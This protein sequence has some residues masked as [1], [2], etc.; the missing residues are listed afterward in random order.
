MPDQPT[1][2]LI[3]L[4]AGL[5]G[6]TLAY[7]LR[8]SGLAVRIL[9]ARDRPG[10]RICTVYADH[11]APLELGATWLGRK[12]AALWALLEVLGLEVFAQRQGPDAHWQ[13]EA[14]APAQRV[15][16]PPNPEP[17]YRIRG[18]S[19]A[20]ITALAGHLPAGTIIT[21]APVTNLRREGSGVVVTAPNAE[22]HAA[23]VVSTLPP[24]LLFRSV[25][26]D[27]PLPDD[28]Y[29][30][31]A[32]TDTWM[33]HSIKVALTYARPY[34]REDGGSGTFFS[35]T[36]PVTELY[37]HSDADDTTY[38][39]QGFVHPD[40]HALPAR[41][42]EKLIVDQLVRCYGA[43][44][45][46]YVSYTEALWRAEIH[47]VSPD[48]P[49]LPPHQYQGH[50]AYRQPRWEGHLLLAGTETAP[51]FPGYMEGAVRSAEWAAGVL[52]AKV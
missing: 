34:W 31:A 27:P 38:A 18:G 13:A 41:E 16:L 52:T 7:R 6:L 37:D 24:D 42:R 23:R 21:G 2:D 43:W 36:G 32:S 45:G 49:G 51:G 14:G 12:H 35:N 25:P 47:T 19:T 29:R 50:P 17:S 33:S 9:E 3:I 1:P 10:G 26:L 4:G 30:L 22:Y 39:L 44:F 28:L 20:L 48:A 11:T 46:D 5:T 40:L 15:R 8:D